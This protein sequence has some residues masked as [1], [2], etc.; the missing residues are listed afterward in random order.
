LFVAQQIKIFLFT[1]LEMK[2]NGKMAKWQDGK[3]VRW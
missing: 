3:M 1:A 2:K